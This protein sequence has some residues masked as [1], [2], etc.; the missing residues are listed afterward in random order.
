MTAVAGQS[1]GDHPIVL[2]R[3]HADASAAD[4]IAVAA[5]PLAASLRAFREHGARWLPLH[6]P[7]LPAG[8]PSPN[9]AGREGSGRPT[10]PSAHVT[11]PARG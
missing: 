10:A 2:D 5:E 6:N 4:R 1:T 8:R 7:T 9:K 11:S 3:P